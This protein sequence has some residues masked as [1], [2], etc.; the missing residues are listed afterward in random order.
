M[1]VAGGWRF[2]PTLWPSVIAGAA[3]AV[4]LSL[5]F[6]QLARM[7]EKNAIVAERT[8]RLEAPPIDVDRAV[9]DPADAEGRRIVL[10][11][12]FL[13]E[14]ELYLMGRSYEGMSGLHVITPLLLADGRAVLVDR[15]WVPFARRAPASRPDGQ[16]AAEVDV[17][18]V[19]R[20]GGWGGRLY[21]KPNNLPAEN[22]WIY[23]DVPA[24]AKAA[25]LAHPAQFYVE[26]SPSGDRGI[27]PIA[28]PPR[29]EVVNDHLGYALTWFALAAG[30]T[31]I[32]ILFHLHRPEDNH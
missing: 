3:L 11:G 18:G 22:H 5:G 16:I 10:R 17:D 28:E 6:W 27:L 23:V 8:A 14:H 24:M 32:Y 21:F 30:L 31:A 4:L 9:A 20:L 7:H 15:G 29:I 13:N 1:A 26:A 25:G 2:R 19:V 12:R